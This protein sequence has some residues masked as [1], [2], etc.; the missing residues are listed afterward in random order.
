MSETT[1]IAKPRQKR[2]A[3][4]LMEK[5]QAQQQE[6]SDAVIA[7][8][9][10][11]EEYQRAQPTH[12]RMQKGDIKRVVVKGEG[13]RFQPRTDVLK[14]YQNKWQSATEVAF[15]RLVDDAKAREVT[16]ITMG[17][18][19]S[20]GGG[21]SHNRMGGI[22]SA[23]ARKIEA[24]NRFDVVMGSLPGR[25]QRLCGWLL[26]GEHVDGGRQVTLEDV[27]RYI[28]PSL[29]DR[30]SCEMIGLGAMVATGEMLASAYAAYDTGQKFHEVRTRLVGVNG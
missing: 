6:I 21:N 17:Y 29:T 16:N 25:L 24:G 22:G 8:K 19:N 14:R 12:E 3:Q 18:G 13:V 28:F 20:G 30:R 11:Q 7:F 10:E 2:L 4:M 27:G 5:R 26:L 15:L 1:I 9:R 23:H